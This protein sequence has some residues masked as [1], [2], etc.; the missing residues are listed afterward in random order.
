MFL[1]GFYPGCV[2]FRRVFQMSHTFTSISFPVCFTLRGARATTVWIQN[3]FSYTVEPELFFVLF[4]ISQITVLYVL[5]F[6][7]RSILLIFA[8]YLPISLH[9]YLFPLLA[10][11]WDIVFSSICRLCLPIFNEKYTLKNTAGWIK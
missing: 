3:T 6:A 4:L 10:A 7:P 11:D 2:W 1:A 5:S 8:V 9:E